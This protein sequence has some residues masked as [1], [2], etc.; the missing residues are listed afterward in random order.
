MATQETAGAADPAVYE[1]AGEYVNHHLGFLTFGQHPDGSWGFAHSAA[2]ASAM[3]F[4]S[5][6]VDTMGISLLTGLLFLWL[7]HSVSK[8]MTSGVPGRLQNAVEFVV[9]MVQ[10]TVRNSFH[11]NN[12][13]IAPLAL[14]IFCWILFMNA[15]D[16]VPVD[17]IPL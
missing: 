17:W 1:S 14:T 12:P 16:L 5:I 7:F 2:E 15:L 13:V 3:G 9:E 10:D 11:G 4:W 6:H 8:K